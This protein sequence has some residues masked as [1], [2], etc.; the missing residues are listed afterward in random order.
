MVRN[1][2]PEC[3][4][5]MVTNGDPLNLN[6]LKKLFQ[7]GL[8]RILISAYDGKEDADK[9]EDLCKE[10]Q[11]SGDQYIVRHRYYTEEQDFGITL[12][13]P[14][15][16]NSFCLILLQHRSSFLAFAISAGLGFHILLLDKTL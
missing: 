2:L 8:N 5:E 12:P 4:I 9:L 6:R 1:S 14:S 16:R 7:S 15:L 3:N 11:L 10:A 13:L